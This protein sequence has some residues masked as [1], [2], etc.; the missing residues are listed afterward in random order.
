L[1]TD[2]KLEEQVKAKDA[3]S[4]ALTKRLA[5]LENLAKQFARSRAPITS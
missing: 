1:R 3:E 5:G 4:A 2:Q